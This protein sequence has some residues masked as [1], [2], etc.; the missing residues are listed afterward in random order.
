VG[1]NGPQGKINA[2][3]SDVVSQLRSRPSECAREKLQA[4]RASSNAGPS[5]ST[6]VFLS[7]RGVL[8]P[9]LLRFTERAECLAPADVTTVRGQIDSVVSDVTGMLVP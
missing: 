9:T 3:E 1:P 4:G 2:F 8:P 5:R 7:T 6:G